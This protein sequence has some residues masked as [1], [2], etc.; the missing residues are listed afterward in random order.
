MRIEREQGQFDHFEYR[1][2]L[3]LS[4]D[5]ERLVQTFRKKPRGELDIN[6]ASVEQVPNQLFLVRRVVHGMHEGHPF[7]N[8][9]TV[10]AE[11]KTRLRTQVNSEGH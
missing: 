4:A 1:R 8:Q 5:E 7:L 10:E 11:H 3:A 9:P 6:E 2:L